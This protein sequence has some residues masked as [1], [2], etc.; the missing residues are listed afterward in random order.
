MKIELK[1]G[2]ALIVIALLI[3]PLLPVQG[4][5]FELSRGVVVALGL[6]LVVISILPEHAY[7]SLLYRRL[8]LNRHAGKRVDR[9]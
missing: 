5:L 7:E 9:H 8:L 2:I 6:V 1:I 3:E 4:P